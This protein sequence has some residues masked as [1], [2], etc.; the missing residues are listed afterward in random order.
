MD[1]VSLDACFQ[2]LFLPPFFPA[3]FACSWFDADTILLNENIPW[4]L[5]LPPNTGIFREINLLISRDW[6]GFNAGIFLIRVCEWSIYTLTDAI[7]L[8]RLKPDIPL[9][10]R[11]QDALKWVFE[12]S[13][14][15]KHRLYQP[16][17]WFNAY[18]FYYTSSG[19]MILNGSLVVHFPGMGEARPD[20]MGKWFD[21]LD[22]TPEKLRVPLENTSYPAEIEAYWS[23]VKSAAIILQRARDWLDKVQAT[24]NEA[25]ASTTRQLA[26]NVTDAE[27]S[28]R[29]L[30]QEDPMDAKRM[31]EQ[32]LRLDRLVREGRRAVER[33]VMRAKD[34]ISRAM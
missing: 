1:S 29:D 21:I 30:M 31:R 20:G 14:N 10:F 2:L 11:E 28:L 3:N 8:P 24:A 23:R 12:Q 7:A 32:V 19:E 34:D 4:T 33:V 13:H 9:P 22:H 6:Q 27:I 25:L 18:D 5:F 15:K 26:D 17:H 16:R